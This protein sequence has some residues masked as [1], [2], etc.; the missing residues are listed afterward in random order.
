MMRWMPDS[1]RHIYKSI[2]PNNG[3]GRLERRDWVSKSMIRHGLANDAA[4]RVSVSRSP[5]VDKYH[6]LHLSWVVS[7]CDH[8][9][10]AV[11]IWRRWMIQGV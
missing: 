7:R 11:R 4:G 2:S 5:N 3:P 8:L 6:H 10:A 1:S 9:E